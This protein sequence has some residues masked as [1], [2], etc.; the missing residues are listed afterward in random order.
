MPS[1]TIFCPQCGAPNSS[2]DTVC[3]CGKA[4]PPQPPHPDIVKLPP[5]SHP[6]VAGAE[7]KV[8][9]G[10]CGILLGSLGVHKFILGYP[11]EGAIMLAASVIGAW[12]SC[13]I[14]P[15]VVGIIGIVEGIIYLAKPDAEFA[16]TYVAS[17][18][19]WF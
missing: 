7:R 19:G 14:V 16:K 1:D 6:V 12:L 9:A 15:V 8:A 2:A 18:K 10:V 17:K 4:L 13:G 3:K 11:V 5:D